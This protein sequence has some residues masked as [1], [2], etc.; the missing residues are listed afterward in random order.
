MLPHTA[1]CSWIYTDLPVS[2]PPVTCVVQ[3]AEMYHARFHWALDPAPALP[4]NIS[5]PFPPTISVFS[6]VNTGLGHAHAGP[7]L[8]GGPQESQYPTSN[9][10]TPQS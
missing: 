1:L 4:D 3:K 7:C 6:G 8:Q 9:M 5:H 10:D 2:L